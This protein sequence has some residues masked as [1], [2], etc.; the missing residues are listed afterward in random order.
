RRAVAP[1]LLQHRLG[2]DRV[3]QAD[4]WQD[5]LQLAALEVA[6]EVPGEA[7]AP[8]PLLLLQVLEAVLA[9]PPHPPLRPQS[10]VRSP[11]RLC[12]PTDLHLG[13]G[14]LADP[15][16]IG[17]DPRRVEVCDWLHHAYSIQ[18]RPACLPVRSPSRRWE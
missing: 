10:H 4:Q 11:H 2:G 13:S 1:E 8:A 14:L 17:P 9:P 7:L 15:V 16:Q 6:D 5:P 18:A 12:R 3:D